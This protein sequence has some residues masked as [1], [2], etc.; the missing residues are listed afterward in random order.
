MSAKALHSPAVHHGTAPLQRQQLLSRMGRSDYYQ[1][2]WQ[3][4]QGGCGSRYWH[5]VWSPS[6]RKGK[7]DGKDTKFPRYDAKKIENPSAP[8]STTALAQEPVGPPEGSLVG[9]LQAHINAARKA[10]ARVA[11][12]TEEAKDCPVEHLRGRPSEVLPT[13][14]GQVPEGYAKAG[15]RSP[16]SSGDTR[17]AGCIF[18]AGTCCIAPARGDHRCSDASHRTRTGSALP[19]R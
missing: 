19:D 4:D 14:E 3:K 12:L 6:Y 16:G 11:S 5:G 15:W 9:A 18:E 8:S 7:G 10:E 2:G 17:P 1:G 13:G